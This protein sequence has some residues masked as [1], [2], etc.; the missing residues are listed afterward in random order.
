MKKVLFVFIIILPLVVFGILIL[1]NKSTTPQNSGAQNFSP[2]LK[3]LTINSLSI[4]NFTISW[5]EITNI[6]NLKLIPNFSEKLSSREVMDEYSCKFVSNSVFYAA[7]SSSAYAA[8]SGSAS[9]NQ[10]LGLFIADS[11]KMAS[12]QEN[13]LFDGILSI[14]D[15]ATPRITRN[16]PQDNLM[17]AIQS[18][19][20]IKENNE[21]QNLRINED[22]KSRRVVAAV[23]GENKL[24]FI[25]VYDPSSQYSGPLLANLPSLLKDFENTSKLTFADILN[26]DGGS[27][28]TFNVLDNDLSEL[29]PVGA[30]F[31]QL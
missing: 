11:Q 27:A 22:G 3:N 9:S 5:F 7:N 17:I 1:N 12:W 16:V 23:T 30:F 19:P 15:M 4:D 14:N 31:C 29:T 21:F 13:P 28:S 10:P 18:G 6:D 20:F 2:T 24:F 26:L 8:G 25:V